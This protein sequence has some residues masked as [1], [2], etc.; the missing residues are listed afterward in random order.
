MNKNRWLARVALLA[1]GA[2]LCT[3]PLARCVPHVGSPDV[4][5]TSMLEV[6]PTSL[7]VS[8][9]GGHRVVT[10]LGTIRNPSGNCFQNVVLEL[11]Y[12]DS[13][14]NHI[15]TVVETMEGFVVPAGETVEFRVREPASRDPAAYASQ[16]VRLVDA[17]MRWV[18]G[19]AK[20]SNRF[21][22]LLLSWAPMLLLI[23]VW[24]YFIR[25]Q[26][27]AKSIQGRMIAIMEQQLEVAKAQGLAIQ[28]AA[29]AL[30]RRGSGDSAT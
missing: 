18:K 2:G 19:S 24:I 15:D 29:A 28:H 3:S 17:D 10:T 20:E 16:A 4:V 27:N 12:F 5:D 11:Q 8:A 1:F 26:S 30:E 23:G 7:D 13:S 22:D 9:D 6:Q 21:V 25:R 14:K